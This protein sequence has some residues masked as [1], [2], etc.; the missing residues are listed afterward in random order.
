MPES[1]VEVEGLLKRYGD[2]TAVDEALDLFAALYPRHCPLEEL[3]TTFGLTETRHR[4]V[5]RLSG[6]Q[7]QRLALALAL[8]NDPELIILDE[9]S[10][11]LDP[12]ARRDL[13]ALIE[14]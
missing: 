6:G 7:R 10:V 3:I 14:G 2:V 5:R 9:P 4:L 8:V 12:A 11:G 1:A 13:W